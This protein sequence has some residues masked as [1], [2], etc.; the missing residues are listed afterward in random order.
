MV[1]RI[2]D[3]E[4]RKHLALLRKLGLD[5]EVRR[6]E[7][8]LRSEIAFGSPPKTPSPPP[9]GAVSIA[10]ASARLS[11]PR[12]EVRRRIELGLLQSETD[13]TTGEAMVTNASI[14]RL[15]EFRRDLAIIAMPLTGDRE[16]VL[17]PN[18]FLGTMFVEA[19]EPYPDDEEE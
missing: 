19:N 12:R 14:E 17:D 1:T 6:Y 18:S 16:D 3:E 13:S 7:A 9:S 5:E 2:L 11:L 8:L 10:E 15:L 4:D